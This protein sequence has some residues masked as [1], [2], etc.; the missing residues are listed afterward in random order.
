MSC[1][2]LRDMGS[3]SISTAADLR[4][5]LRGAAASLTAQ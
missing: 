1:Q 4:L 2:D 5:R 3:D